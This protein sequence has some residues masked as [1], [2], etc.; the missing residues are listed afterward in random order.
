MIMVKPGLPY[1][2]VVRAL[3]ESS[4]LP[5]AVYNVSGEYAMLRA[6]SEKG[7]LDYRSTVAEVLTSFKRAGA[8]IILTY[9]A[10]EFAQW[11][12]ES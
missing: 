2:D 10:K 1:L 6:A 9:H 12:S 7:W 4:N 11:Q 3:A 8:N 5:I